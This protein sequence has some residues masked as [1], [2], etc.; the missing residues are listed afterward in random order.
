MVYFCSVFLCLEVFRGHCGGYAGC[1]LGLC[2]RYVGSSLEGENNEKLCEQTIAILLYVH[3]FNAPYS[4]NSLVFSYVVLRFVVGFRC[5]F[6]G[7]PSK[8]VRKT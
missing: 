2:W 1:V 8:C 4:A 7:F 3:A 5:I 6:L